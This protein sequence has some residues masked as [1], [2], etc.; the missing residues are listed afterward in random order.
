MYPK[1]PLLSPR[2]SD[3][4]YQIT[5][6]ISL[7][8]LFSWSTAYPLEA[9]P[10]RHVDIIRGICMHPSPG[11][12]SCLYSMSLP[13]FPRS[14]ESL[15]QSHTQHVSKLNESILLPQTSRVKAVAV[16]S[17]S[18]SALSHRPLFPMGTALFF[19]SIGQ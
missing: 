1:S 3:R 4:N 8:Y 9:Q 7:F 18:S 10:L 17:Y 5:H 14:G 16:I 2:I 13:I 11:A 15:P 19:A 6:L 12:I